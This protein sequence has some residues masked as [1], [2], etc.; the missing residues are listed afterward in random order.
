MRLPPLGVAKRNPLSRMGS[1]DQGKVLVRCEAGGM[2]DAKAVV[3]AKN[4]QYRKANAQ[5]TKKWLPRRAERDPAGIGGR[6]TE[7]LRCEKAKREIQGSRD[8]A[9]P[10]HEQRQEITEPGATDGGRE[11]GFRIWT[12]VVAWGRRIR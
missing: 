11:V 7:K 8:A 6:K 10:R 2:R 9:C 3:N 1:R 12:E 4:H 5:A